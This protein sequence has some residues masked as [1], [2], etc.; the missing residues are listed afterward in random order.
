[1]R[2]QRNRVFLKTCPPTLA[3]AHC[4]CRKSRSGSG[5]SLKCVPTNSAHCAPLRVGI[6]YDVIPNMA[7]TFSAGWWSLK[8]QRVRPPSRHRSV[9]GSRSQR[10]ALDHIEVPLPC[11]HKCQGDLGANESCLATRASSILFIAPS[12]LAS[13]KRRP[14][15][16]AGSM[17][18]YSA[19]SPSE[20][21][22]WRVLKPRT[23][24]AGLKRRAALLTFRL[25][26]GVSK[27]PA[28]Y[29]RSAAL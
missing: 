26:K 24:F 12:Q 1:V 23:C 11:V 13:R 5:V 15:A 28:A 29:R 3:R 4:S 6:R 16:C 19:P 27:I 25:L 2:V 10:I 9:T 14:N 18:H 7:S 21:R 22:T 8:R 17:S 20:R